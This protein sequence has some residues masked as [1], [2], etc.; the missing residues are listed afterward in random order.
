MTDNWT[1][2]DAV[3]YGADIL[4]GDEVRFRALS[5]NDLLMLEK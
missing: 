1:I 5:D 2:E 4:C 3:S